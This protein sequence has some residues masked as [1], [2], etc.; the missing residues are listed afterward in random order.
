MQA[1]TFDFVL[2]GLN[3]HPERKPMGNLL[4]FQ[5]SDFRFFRFQIFQILDSDFRFQFV[6]WLWCGVPVVRAMSWG[7]FERARLQPRRMGQLEKAALAAEERS[8]ALDLAPHFVR[9]FSAHTTG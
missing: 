7:R 9:I 5:I 8:L 2:P 6:S 1:Q 4:R 3:D